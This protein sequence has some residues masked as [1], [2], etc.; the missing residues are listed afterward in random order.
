MMLPMYLE[1]L[2]F[3][4]RR[5]IDVL[6]SGGGA[7]RADLARALNVSPPTL[8]RLT[9]NLLDKGLVEEAMPENRERT[10]GQP[11]KILTINEDSLY[12]VGIYFDPDNIH[13]CLANL[14]GRMLA[15]RN[16]AVGDRS[17]TAI[18]GEVSKITRQMRAEVAISTDR[19]I[20][21]GLSY[22]GQ[23]TV[24]PNYVFRIKQFDSWPEIN[25]AKDFEAYFDGPVYHSNDAKAVCLA[26]LYYG[27]CQTYRDIAFVWLS[28][29]IGGA[30]VIGRQLY[31][32]QKRNAAEFGGLFP[33]SMPR[34][35]GQDLLDTLNRAGA[36]LNRISE[37]GEHHRNMPEMA[38]WTAR[39]IEQLRWLCL[40]I[41]RTMDPEAIVFGGTLPGWILEE[42]VASLNGDTRLGED[43]FLEKPK[44]LLSQFSRT[45]QIGA[46]AIPIHHAMNPIEYDGPALKGW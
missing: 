19:L 1:K 31:T 36:G 3:N 38:A 4:E 26:E 29:G 45:P 9:A 6:R 20:G 27:A 33:K 44:I 16:Y 42:V 39:A 32:G 28:Y 14:S 15:H 46:S 34:P 8:T 7:S 17:F 22:P 41:C 18:M 43:F 24:N 30:S 21:Y 23:F 11:S 10:V 2:T 13:C 35:S 12:T 25:I 5:I 37:I 40:V